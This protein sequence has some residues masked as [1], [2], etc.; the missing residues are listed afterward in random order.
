[1]C[2]K[3]KLAENKGKIQ[4]QNRPRNIEIRGMKMKKKENGGS[5]ERACEKKDEK[6]CGKSCVKT[7][8]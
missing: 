4:I 2:T 7:A 5:E 6:L 8:M 3:E 1:M